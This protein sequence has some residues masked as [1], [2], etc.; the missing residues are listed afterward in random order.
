MFPIRADGTVISR[1]THSHHRASFEKTALLPV[2]AVV[3]PV[4]LIMG[5]GWRQFEEITG[6]AS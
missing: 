5:T 1:K 4:K 6:I 3:I 2:E